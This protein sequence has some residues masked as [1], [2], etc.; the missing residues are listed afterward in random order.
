MMG[1]LNLVITTFLIISKLFADNV[2]TE[3][4]KI[5]PQHQPWW[6]LTQIML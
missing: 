5:L 3:N 4:F 1:K 2:E 6:H